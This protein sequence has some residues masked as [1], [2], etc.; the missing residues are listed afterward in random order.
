MSESN[1][2]SVIG[3][4]KDR[5]MHQNLSKAATGQK[6]IALGIKRKEKRKKVKKKE[7]KKRNKNNTQYE[8][9]A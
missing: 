8:K 4:G 9:A 7:K 1:A 5:A 6:N 3:N 2:I